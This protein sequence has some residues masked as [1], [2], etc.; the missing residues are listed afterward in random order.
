MGPLLAAD[1]AK[2]ATQLQQFAYTKEVYFPKGKMLKE[3]ESC[4]RPPASM[5]D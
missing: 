4:G 3:G 2:Y 1:V 5:V